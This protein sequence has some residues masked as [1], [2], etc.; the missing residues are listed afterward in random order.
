M[1]PPE[2]GTPTRVSPSVEP[3]TSADASPALSPGSSAKPAT[4][5]SATT[6]PASA[7]TPVMTAP[8]YEWPTSTTGPSRL[9]IRSVSRAVSVA[10]PRRGL[11]NAITR[12]PAGRRPSSP[13]QLVE[14][15]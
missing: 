13:S 14:S 1:P 3:G 5:T 10:S 15:A 9:L 12:P 4:Y 2:S 11:A 8:P 6:S 7:G